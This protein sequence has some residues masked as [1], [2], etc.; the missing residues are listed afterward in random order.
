MRSFSLTTLISV[1]F[2][3]SAF[4]SEPPNSPAVGNDNPGTVQSLSVTAGLPASQQ[5]NPNAP[6]LIV[7]RTSRLQ[8]IVTARFDSGQLRDR[9]HHVQYSAEPKGIIDI[10]AAGMVAPLADGTVTIT[11]ADSSG[12]KGS[13]QLTVQQFANPPRINFANQV[14]PIFTKLG[15]NGGGCHGK[16]GGQNGFQLSLL[17]F[18]AED[19]YG[20]LVKEA[21]GRR[22]FPAAPD[23]SLLLQKAVG[24][25]PHGGGPRLKTDSDEYRLL[26]LWIEQGM[27]Y[28]TDEDPVL[29]RISVWP[30]SRKMPRDGRQQLKVVAH[31]SD[32]SARDVTRQAQF[33]PNNTELADA[34]E[35][36]HVEMKGR[37]GVVAVMVRDQGQVD[38][39]L[40]TVPLGAPIDGLPPERSFI[41]KH[42]FA[43][44]IELGL[45]PSPV[46]D[47]ATYLRR[48]TVDIAGRLPTPEETRK[49]LSDTSPQKRAA[50][51]DRLLD[52]NEYA[53]YFAQKWA[54]IL[55][56]RVQ[57]NV[58]RN[59]NILFHDW[60]RSRLKENMPYDQLVTQII[61]A[62]GDVRN[63]PAVNWHRHLK[64]MDEKVEDTAQVFLGQR[65]QCAKCHHH[66]FE[67]WGQSDYWGLAAFYSNVREKSGQRVYVQRGTSQAQNPKTKQMLPPTR[68][69][70]EPYELTSDDD[71]RLA[72]AEWMTASDN[73]YFARTLVNRYWKHFLGVGIVD[74]E[75]DMRA[76]NPPTNPALL[77][78]LADHFTDVRFDLKA[79]IRTICGSSTYQLSS[80]PNQYNVSDRQSFSKFYPRRL[81]A[82]VILDGIDQLMGTT[83]RFSGLPNGTRATQIPDHGAVN[84]FFL[85]AFGR[86]GG[87]SASECERSGDRSMSI[88]LQ[89]LNSDDV[90][91][92]L[93][94]SRAREMA[95]DETR[96]AAAKVSELYLRAFSR[97]P[98]D[99]ELKPLLDH[100]RAISE[101]DKSQ[102]HD[103]YED[104]LW[105]LMNTKEF[106]FNH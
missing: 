79:L 47:D 94:G 28:G 25:V 18:E 49:F 55:R 92:K 3:P 89:L 26:R 30:K 65:I 35:E 14:V 36:G 54:S 76:T 34:S 80:V 84:N 91:N 99:S 27:P 1:L 11:A 59:G 21:R 105:T 24:S 74:P 12:H 75:D 41:D 81:P 8:L 82:E 85:D 46:C 42:V 39:F 48:V 66:P 10:S 37:P 4:S 22:I 102:K 16:S 98:K 95:S 64:S 40:A 106:L 20:Y 32:G 61:T 69:G 7:G 19:D 60:L 78:A 23:R 51:V 88:S 13:T 62:S 77:D 67:K 97:L 44:L 38:A 56:N 52:S 103:A 90:Y 29:E 68:L 101:N 45:P 6:G 43:Q 104:I 15:C 72:L 5:A 86:P 31:F 87:A 58:P 17:G 9:T 93:S 100:I 71:A 2:V 57:Q 83:T 73:P 50:L 70:G 53:D 63:N 33:T 96:D